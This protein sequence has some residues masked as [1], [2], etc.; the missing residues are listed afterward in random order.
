VS[1]LDSEHEAV[2][3]WKSFE[4][5]K[6]HVRWLIIDQPEYERADRLIAIGMRH[7]PSRTRTA[8]Q[9]C[10]ECEQDWPCWTYT[11][12]TGER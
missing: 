8:S 2:N 4:T 5:A 6:T 12:V 11:A 9:Q 3:E 7:Q 1:L 10:R